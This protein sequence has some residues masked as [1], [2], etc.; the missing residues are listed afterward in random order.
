MSSSV[1]S[2]NETGGRS[3]IDP[4]VGLFAIFV[5]SAL[6]IGGGTGSL[7]YLLRII[8]SLLPL[9][10]LLGL[11]MWKFSAVYAVLY[12]LVLLFENTFFDISTGILNIILLFF[13]TLVSRFLPPIVLAYCVMK[14][15]TVSEFVTAL[16][17]MHVPQAIII[18]LSVMFRFFPTIAEENTAIHDAMRMRQIGRKRTSLMRKLEFETVPV[19]MSTVRIAD[20]L[21]QASLTKGLGSERKRTHI[22]EV[23]FRFRDYLLLILMTA[24]F[25]L[26]LL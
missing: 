19:M 11:R 13:I 3:L 15:T 17:R 2:F 18:P 7:D 22:C 24:V 5:S 4:R 6:L 21:S 16:E 23:G 26:Y 14:T 12:F 10:F 25:I 9:F 20:E 1:L 8:C